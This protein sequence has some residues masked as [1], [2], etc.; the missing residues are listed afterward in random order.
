MLDARRSRTPS[1][2]GR[3]IGVELTAPAAV[4]DL[5]VYPKAPGRPG[6]GE[7]D[8]PLRALSPPI[9][10]PSTTRVSAAEMTTRLPGNYQPNYQSN[11]Q[12]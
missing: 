4:D 9:T 12:P 7:G 6:R 11:Y 10:T 5:E 3:S 8:R 2:R 1:V